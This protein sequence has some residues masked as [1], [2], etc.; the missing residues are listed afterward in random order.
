MKVNSDFQVKIE[1]GRRHFLTLPDV[2]PWSMR[3]HY[4][5]VCAFMGNRVQVFLN[6]KCIKDTTLDDFES[7]GEILYQHE[8]DFYTAYY[9]YF[10]GSNNIEIHTVDAP[11]K[12]KFTIED[13]KQW[14]LENGY[15]ADDP[16]EL[17]NIADGENS[18]STI[19]LNDGFEHLLPDLTA[20]K[21]LIRKKCDSFIKK[22]TAMVE[23]KGR[24]VKKKSRR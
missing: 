16:E 8:G 5:T 3:Q 2:P 23:Y 18:E 6:E 19:Q 21:K 11:R 12:K 9:M 24:L 13:A 10:Y 14:L 20:A 22:N 17:K 15:P 4:G 7:L 1:E